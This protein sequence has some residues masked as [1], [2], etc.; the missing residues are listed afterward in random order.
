MR[1]LELTGEQVKAVRSLERAFRKCAK[2]RVYIH[3]CY[4]NLIAYDGGVV[5]CVDDEET[6]IDC[7]EGVWIDTPH[8]LDLASWADDRH[9]VHRL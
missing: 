5:K 1:G 3:N 7:G 4:G 6:D 8:E 9:Y 2:A